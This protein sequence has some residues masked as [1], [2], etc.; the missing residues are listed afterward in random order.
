MVGRGWEIALRVLK[1]PSQG[2]VP[3]A[4]HRRGGH[5]G[6]QCPPLSTRWLRARRAVGEHAGG[7]ETAA[8]MRASAGPGTPDGASGLCLRSPPGAIAAIKAL[9]PASTRASGCCE[10]PIHVLPPHLRWTWTPRPA[11]ALPVSPCPILQHSAPPDLQR[12]PCPMPSLKDI[13][14]K[15]HVLPIWNL[16]MSG[17]GY[18]PKDTEIGTHLLILGLTPPRVFTT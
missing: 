18:I 12:T 16:V 9:P 5:S 17:H 11:P 13:W 10:K 6:G 14:G 7:G 2:R 4:E 8:A 15:G 3:P 1:P